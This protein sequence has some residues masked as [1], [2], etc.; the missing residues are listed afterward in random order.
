MVMQYMFNSN[1]GTKEQP[2]STIQDGIQKAKTLFIDDGS[3]TAE[4]RVAQGTYTSDFHNSGARDN[5]VISMIDGISVYGG[6]SDD[7]EDKNTASY[8]T[9]IVDSSTDGGTDNSPNRAV[10]FT[11]SFTKETVLDGLRITI[12]AGT[13]NTGI[14]CNATSSFVAISNNTIRGHDRLNDGDNGY[15]ITLIDCGSLVIEEND[16]NPE[17]SNTNSYGIYCDNSTATIEQNIIKGGSAEDLEYTFTLGIFATGNNAPMIINNSKIDCGSKG[18]NGQRYGI[19]LNMLSVSINLVIYN[20]EFT[21]E[22]SGGA[23]Y[24]IYEANANSD[25]YSVQN[26]FFNY[27]NGI[28]YL[29]YNPTP[30]PVFWNEI[31]SQSISTQS[32]NGTLSSFGNLA[33]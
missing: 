30:D 31:D 33:P 7:F 32:G 29:D 16:I 2:L 15:G 11:V 5:P 26:N 12:G 27:Q 13:H 18:D 10:E 17:W 8:L 14:L 28:Y 24:F 4:V 21:N 23:V 22:A 9:Q 6:Y 1:P 19:Y 25:P 20:N 3:N